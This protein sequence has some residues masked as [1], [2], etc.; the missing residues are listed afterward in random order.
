M[1]Y[2]STAYETSDNIYDTMFVKVLFNAWTYHKDPYVDENIHL[3]Y[4]I[5]DAIGAKALLRVRLHITH[6][7]P[8]AELSDPHLDSEGIPCKICCFY[9]NTN[10]GGTKFTE[11]GRI[12][13][14]VE[15]RAVTF[16]SELYHSAVNTTDTKFRYVLNINYF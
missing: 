5:L 13:R 7:T 16:P 8:E 10:N 6:A 11:S 4:P 2:E 9:L 1:P 14:S 3:I 12:V 15:N